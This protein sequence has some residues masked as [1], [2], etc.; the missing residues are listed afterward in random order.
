LSRTKLASIRGADL[1]IALDA[2]RLI[3]HGTQ[4]QLVASGG[5]Y[6]TAFRQQASALAPA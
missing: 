6:A 5:H 3:E 4:A 1:I 2:G